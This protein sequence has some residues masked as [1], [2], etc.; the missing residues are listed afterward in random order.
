MDTLDSPGSRLRAKRLECKVAEEP[1]EGWDAVERRTSLEGVELAE[2]M[3]S[4]LP[5][6]RGSS[7]TTDE[8]I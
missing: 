1:G 5:L 7:A 3:F 4:M 2:A 6:D 8:H